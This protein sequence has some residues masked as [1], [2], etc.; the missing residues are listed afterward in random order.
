[1]KVLKSLAI[2]GLC[3]AMLVPTGC[4]T[5]KN[6]SQ[7]GQGATIGGGAGAAVGA[8]IGALIGGGK[9]TWIGAL[10]GGAVGAGTGAAVGHTMDKQKKELEA[11]LAS[12]R[13][14]A[15]QKDTAYIIQTVKDS[16]NLD[17]IRLV[18]GNS[19]LFATG[20]SKLS[21]TAQAALSQVAINLNQNPNTDVT[22]MG[23]TD[24]TG[25]EQLNM[26]L[27]QERANVVMNYLISK[28][29]AANRLKAIGNGWNNPLVSNDTAAGRAQNRRVELYITANQQMIDAA[30]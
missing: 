11:Q 28:G 23:Y 3:V 17:A 6:M 5:F 4:N 24:N 10:V 27:S 16:N 8:G 14:L 20:S 19:I 13:E 12:V 9:G 30:K 7:T 22:V 21:T 25:S 26:K 18:L 2:V 15:A 1:M 29:V